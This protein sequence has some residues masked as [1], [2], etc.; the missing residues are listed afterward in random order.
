MALEPLPADGPATTAAARLLLS[1]PD[2]RA[3][4]T[5]DVLVAA[6]NGLICGYDTAADP[7]DSTSYDRTTAWPVTRPARGADDWTGQVLA[8]CVQGANMLVAR[9]YQRR[10][11]PLGFEQVGELGPV[12]VTRNDPDLA[13]MLRL[14]S[15]AGPVVG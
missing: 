12:Y 13:M 8:S 3:D 5:L 9:L 10:N 7:D 11:S 15:W 2:D 6:V 4:A 14:G 1:I